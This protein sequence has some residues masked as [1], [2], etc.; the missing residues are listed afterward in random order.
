MLNCSTYS[1][2]TDFSYGSTGYVFCDLQLTLCIAVGEQS[3]T[4]NCAYGTVL[5]IVHKHTV[6]GTA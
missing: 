5:Y 6:E 2:A 4:T 1:I 3:E